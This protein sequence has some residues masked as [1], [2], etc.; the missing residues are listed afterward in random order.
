[1]KKIFVFTMLFIT[2]TATFSQ[3]IYSSP[4]LTK[5]DYLK[6]SRHQRSAAALLISTGLLCAGLGTLAVAINPDSDGHDSGGVFFMVTG[7]AVIGSSIPLFI[8]S[9]KNKKK[10]AS[11]SIN[12]EPVSHICKSSLVFSKIPSLTVKINL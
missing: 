7:F 9:S 6:K 12:I 4:T 1:M 10:A 8:A 3:Q 2:A 5:Q 11:L